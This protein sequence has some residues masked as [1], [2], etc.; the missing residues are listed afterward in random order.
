MS[1]PYSVYIIKCGEFI[2][3][4]IAKDINLRLKSH[5]TSNPYDIELCVS[6]D[7]NNRMVARKVE[8]LVH[9]KLK[10]MGLHHRLEWFHLHAFGM[11][12]MLCFEHIKVENEK[13]SE[14]SVKN[15]TEKLIYI[16]KKMMTLEQIREALADRVPAKVAEATGI[17]YNTIRQ[18]RSNPEAN[19]THKVMQKISDYL[20]SRRV[21]HG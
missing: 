13:Q 21:S 6:F 14:K 8:M 9:K 12:S 10:E 11:A 17:N 20:E 7:A 5:K 4:G 1:N 16:G 2:K 15:I 3:I 18:I 19:P